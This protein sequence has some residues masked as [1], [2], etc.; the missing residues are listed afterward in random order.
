MKKTIWIAN[1]FILS[2][3]VL[4]TAT[5]IAEAKITTKTKITSAQHKKVAVV[6]KKNTKK[7]VKKTK[8]ATTTSKILSAPLIDPNNPP[9]GR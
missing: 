8:V 4:G 1:L 2:A 7:K 5:N 6:K 9:G 3:I